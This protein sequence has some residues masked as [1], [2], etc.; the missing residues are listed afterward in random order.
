MH[1]GHYMAGTQDEH[2]AHFNALMAMYRQ[3][4]DTL[5]IAGGMG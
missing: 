1:F 4:Q 3:Q 2:I 5:P